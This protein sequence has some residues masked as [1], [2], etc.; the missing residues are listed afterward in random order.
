MTIGPDLAPLVS[1]FHPS[2][3]NVANTRSTQAEALT[4]I[5]PQDA[6]RNAE[7]LTRRQE[8]VNINFNSGRLATAAN[9][10]SQAGTIVNELQTLATQAT[11][12]TLSNND[13]ALLNQNYQALSQEL[14]N[15]VSNGQFNQQPTLQGGETSVTGEQ[16]IQNP[17]LQDVV[18][19]VSS[20]D[21]SSP[22]NA[23]ATQ[24]LLNEALQTISQERASVGAQA[25]GLGRAEQ[26]SLT[27]AAQIEAGASPSFD[28][29][30]I[31]LQANLT[32][33]QIQTQTAAQL[34]Q[35]QQTQAKTVINLLDT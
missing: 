14:G 18:S 20:G 6:A 24:A 32:A 15:L 33:D 5:S 3:G 7:A 26:R 25:A 27:Q 4:S 22:A 19:T 35:V 30:V 1:Q 13:R 21:L 34:S 11:S 2:A 16:T 29:D 23:E 9:G 10:L 28:A 8:A 12:S 31:A 17:D